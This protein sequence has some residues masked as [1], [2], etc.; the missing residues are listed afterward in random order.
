MSFV[1]R[2]KKIALNHCVL[3]SDFPL[4]FNALF[5]RSPFQ[6]SQSHSI[7]S[8]ILKR[9]KQS[10]WKKKIH[11]QTTQASTATKETQLLSKVIAI[12]SVALHCPLLQLK[13]QF[14]H[15]HWSKN[16]NLRFH[17]YI[18]I[19]IST[20]NVLSLYVKRF[21]HYFFSFPPTRPSTQKHF[22]SS[23]KQLEVLPKARLHLYQQWEKTNLI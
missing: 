16:R 9:N 1:P 19:V 4:H 21:Y 22:R 15:N 18:F 20:P 7:E 5:I 12:C 6:R 17:V 23:L 2:N 14:C 10:S 13:R 8:T 11:L 3:L